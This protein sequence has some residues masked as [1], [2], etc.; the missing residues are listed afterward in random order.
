MMSLYSQVA[1][2]TCVCNENAVGTFTTVLSFKRLLPCTTQPATVWSK[3]AGGRE[4]LQ[5]NG[6]Q[7]DLEGRL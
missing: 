6:T 3:G 7:Y 1:R 2:V 4:G 5:Y